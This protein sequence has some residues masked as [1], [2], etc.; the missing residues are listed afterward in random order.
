MLSLAIGGAIYGFIEKS[1]PGLPTV[2]LVGRAGT[3]AIAA[4]FIGKR[5]GM[6]GGIV[7]DVGKAAAVIAGYQL[8]STGK[9]SGNIPSQV[10][11]IAA[12]V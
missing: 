9:I 10:H 11:G 12:Q 6:G 1:F 3:V 8:G 5:G 4:Y 2:P 7:Q